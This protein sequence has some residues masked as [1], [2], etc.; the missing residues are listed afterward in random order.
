MTRTAR[1]A[2]HLR[3]VYFGGNWSGSCLEENLASLSHQEA[4]EVQ[5]AHNSIATLVFHIDY[6]VR[7]QLD[8][9]QLGVLTAHD[10]KSMACPPIRNESDWDALR[11]AALRNGE[12]LSKSIENLP[13]VQL[14]EIFVEEKYG[15]YER[16]FLG[17]IE[18]CHYH[19]GQIALLRKLLRSEK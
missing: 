19:L 4:T 2:N 13:D 1:I 15:T 16:N 8:V 18:H 5:G 17:L 3:Q 10:R 7:A 11:S 14:D 9:L 6:Y 12:A